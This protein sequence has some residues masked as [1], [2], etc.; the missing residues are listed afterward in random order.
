MRILQEKYMQ[1]AQLSFIIQMSHSVMYAADDISGMAM[2]PAWGN[3]Q[4]LQREHRE[5]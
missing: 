2:F 1:L 3:T 5:T 4:L